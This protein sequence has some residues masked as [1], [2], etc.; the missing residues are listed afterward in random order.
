MGVRESRKCMRRACERWALERRDSNVA[1]ED[2]LPLGAYSQERGA[3]ASMRR[4]GGC[5]SSVNEREASLS[6]SSSHGKLMKPFLSSGC[7]S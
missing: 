3:E 6:R 7:F 2:S 5:A 1:P 4:V